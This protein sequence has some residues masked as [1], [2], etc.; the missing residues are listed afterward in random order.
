MD[1]EFKKSVLRVNHAGEYGAIRIYEG[2]LSIL[3][4]AEDVK[5]IGHMLEQERE[6]FKAFDELM[7][8]HQIRPTILQPLWRVVGFCLGAGTAILGREAAMACTVAVETAIDE[9]Y[10]AQEEALDAQEDQSLIEIIQKFRE[11]EREHKEQALEEGAENAPGYELLQYL[12]YSG[13]KIA[14]ELSKRF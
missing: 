4:S 3:K 5:I 9:H 12:I 8:H 6:H 13:S 2:Q 11:E 1:D 10:S 7:I 14:I